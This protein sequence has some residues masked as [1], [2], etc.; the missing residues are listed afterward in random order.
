MIEKLAAE[1][2]MAM[3]DPTISQRFAALGIS[4]NA[5]GPA[6]F[7]TEI[8]EAFALWGEVVRSAGLQEK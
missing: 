4:P 2:Q 8:K 7:A 5:H 6:R 3:N 1:V